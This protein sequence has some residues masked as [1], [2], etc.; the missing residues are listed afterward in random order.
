M[1]FYWSIVD[2]QHCVSFCL[3]AKWVIYTNFLKLSIYLLTL[4][5]ARV[6][7]EKILPL[8]LPS[9]LLHYFTPPACLCHGPWDGDPPWTLPALPCYPSTNFPCPHTCS[10]PSLVALASNLRGSFH[11]PVF[12]S[13]LLS[14][15]FLFFFQNM[16][17]IQPF[18]T[19]PWL[20]SW[21]THHRHSLWLLHFQKWS[22]C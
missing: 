6:S 13:Q 3:I 9:L 2:L 21:S 8:Q 10:S 17:R 11:L 5:Q 4:S 19:L 18:P 16:S 22:L 7:T 20:P 15:Y 14:K 12:L 1:T